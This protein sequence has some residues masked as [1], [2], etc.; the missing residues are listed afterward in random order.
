M[1]HINSGWEII[2]LIGTFTYL[3]AATYGAI[4]FLRKK[5][6]TLIQE[7]IQPIVK[8]V[9]PNGGSSMKDQVNRMGRDIAV[10]K[11]AM[12]DNKNQSDRDF[13][14]LDGNISET[15]RRIDDMVR[16]K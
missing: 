7:A 16:N 14:R 6:V 5:G 10:I 2:T 12:F 3:I 4:R 8:E 9:T 1:G 11:Q 13:N 15:N